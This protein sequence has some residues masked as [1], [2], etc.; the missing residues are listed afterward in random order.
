MI[1]FFLAFDFDESDINN[2]LD[3]IDGQEFQRTK[4]PKHNQRKEGQI[5][6]AYG[7]LQDILVAC[8]PD[9]GYPIQHCEANLVHLLDSK[10]T[11]SH[12]KLD[13]DQCT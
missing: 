13:A 5:A 3:T 12:Y 4:Q 6:S 10:K 11:R 1:L 9:T 7:Y 2:K 8:I